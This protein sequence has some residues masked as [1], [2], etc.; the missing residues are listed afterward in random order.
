MV[1]NDGLHILENLEHQRQLR[2]FEMKSISHEMTV[3]IFFSQMEV[4]V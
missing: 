3:Y 2:H 1:S 4:V